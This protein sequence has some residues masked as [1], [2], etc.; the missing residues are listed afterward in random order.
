[1]P[2]SFKDIRVGG[3]YT[4]KELAE[5]WGYASYQALARGVVTPRADNKIVLFVTEDK[6]Q[7][8]VQYADRL[9]EDILKWEGPTDHFAEERMLRADSSGDEIHLF[10]RERH[11]E[12]FRYCGK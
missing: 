6:Q 10:Y 7:S 3:F 11:R 9:S 12:G 8:A 5:I 2:L 1:M 4:R